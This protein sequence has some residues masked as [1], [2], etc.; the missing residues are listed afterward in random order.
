MN[1]FKIFL[2]ESLDTL[3]ND[4]SIDAEDRL[5]PPGQDVF[6]EKINQD[7]GPGF[8]LKDQRWAMS[9]I[10]SQIVHTAIIMNTSLLKDR[11]DGEEELQPEHL[12]A[13]IFHSATAQVEYLRG[14]KKIFK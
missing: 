5:G 1:C 10:F 6:L 12:E 4:L 13:S 11:V 7:L 14:K 3:N 8:S 9:M 2:N